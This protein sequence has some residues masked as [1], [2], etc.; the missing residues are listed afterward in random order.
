MKPAAANNSNRC[1]L[2]VYEP[3]SRKPEGGCVKNGT[4]FAATDDREGRNWWLPWNHETHPGFADCLLPV[5]H[6]H[7]G[8][9]GWDATRFAEPD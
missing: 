6:C 2:A 5:S 4:G 1:Q 8:G 3:E 9:G 7:D